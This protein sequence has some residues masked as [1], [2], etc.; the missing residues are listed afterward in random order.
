MINKPELLVPGGSLDKIKVALMYGADAVYAGVPDLSLREKA[1]M[2]YEEVEEAINLSHQ[3][4]KKMYLAF[5][6][7]SHNKDL[8]KVPKV[9]EMIKRLNPDGLII[10]DPGIFMMVHKALPE[11]PLHVSTQANVCSYET[12]NFWK[13]MGAKLCVLARE[14]SFEEIKEI[15]EKVPDIRLEMFIHGAMC[16]SYSGRCLLSNYMTGRGA[17]QGNC[18]QSCRWKY[19]VHEK[20]DEAQFFLEEDSRKGEYMPIIE[21]DRGTFIMSSKDMCLMPR[22]P[23]LVE[24]GIDVFKLEGRN[25]SAY[26]VATVTRAYR[27]AIDAYFENPEAFDFEPFQAE[28][29]TL[30]NRGYT[31]GFFDG[32]PDGG[33]Q[34]YE[35]TRSD[36]NWRTAGLVVSLSSDGLQLELKNAV[37]KGDKIFLL[38]PSRFDAYEIILK[39]LVDFNSGEEKDMFSAGQNQSIL[40]KKEWLPEN[41]QT[42]FPRLT[43]ARKK[44]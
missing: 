2:T 11:M 14:V 13:D 40:I 43:M 3:M 30:Q 20:K 9:V 31:F 22:L 5:N 39:D 8:P 23:E 21:N 28:L 35:S 25:K 24:S 32:V 17:N 34:T 15:R 4:G 1:K 38:S 41:W 18:A 12:I 16:M 42:L 7:F 44:I 26:Y 36:G 37:A 6:I 19:R 27:N 10:S 29:D 33:A